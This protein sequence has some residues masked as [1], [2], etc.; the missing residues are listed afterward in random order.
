MESRGDDAAS[1]KPIAHRHEGPAFVEKSPSKRSRFRVLQGC[2]ERRFLVVVLPLKLMSN[3]AG[4]SSVAKGLCLIGDG[5]V[6]VEFG[7]RQVPIPSA[8]YRANGY[9]PSCDK[10]PLQALPTAIA[11]AGSAVTTLTRAAKGR[12]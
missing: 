3:A 1:H 9:K 7:K 8:Q 10:L 5:Q 4:G 11:E 12:A 2:I 6:L